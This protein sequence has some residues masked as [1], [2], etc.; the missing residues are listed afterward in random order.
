MSVSYLDANRFNTEIINA[1]NMVLVDFF[2]T[3]CGPCQ[4]MAPVL[5]DIS[6][7]F[8]YVDVYKLDIDE[9]PELCREY[10]VDSVPTII[11]FQ[12]GEEIERFIGVTGKSSIANALRSYRE[13]D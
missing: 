10:D 2:A 7:E 5:E 4:M 13:D 3:W 8:D 12:K 11:L 1:D 6:D 9:N